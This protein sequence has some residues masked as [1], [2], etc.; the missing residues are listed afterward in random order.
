M[1]KRMV[2]IAMAL[3]Q[4][5]S[6]QYQQS[7]QQSPSCTNVASLVPFN[8]DQKAGLQSVNV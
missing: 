6:F 5:M 8:K 3:L 7:A 1:T 4:C 2:K